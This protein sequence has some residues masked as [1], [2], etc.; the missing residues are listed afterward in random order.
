MSALFITV[1]D[2]WGD[3]HQQYYL[4]KHAHIPYQLVVH[5]D[6]IKKQKKHGRH[7]T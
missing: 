4:H 2:A 6:F 1:R 3:I 7:L 5:M